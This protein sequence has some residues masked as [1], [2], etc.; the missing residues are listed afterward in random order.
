MSE[1]IL[2]PVDNLH[3]ELGALIAS[4][5]QRLGP[6]V[7]RVEGVGYGLQLLAPA[8]AAWTAAPGC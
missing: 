3:A 5:R 7:L 2:T 6:E 4:R 8:G 1:V